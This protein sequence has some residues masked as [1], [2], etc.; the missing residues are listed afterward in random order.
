MT[1]KNQSITAQLRVAIS[2][3]YLTISELKTYLAC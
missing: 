1:N 3:G 2:K